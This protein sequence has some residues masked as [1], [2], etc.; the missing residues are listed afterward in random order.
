M[1]DN[2]RPVDGQELPDHGVP[3]AD[4]AA[5]WWEQPSTGHDRSRTDPTMIGSPAQFGGFPGAHTPPP[6]PFA[7]SQPFAAPQPPT[8]PYAAPQPPAYGSPP[9]HSAGP[10]GRFPNRPPTR[11]KTP[12]IIAGAV[13]LVLIVAVTVGLFAIAATVEDVADVGDD[14]SQGD[15]AMDNVTNSCDLVDTTILDNWAPTAQPSTHTERKPSEGIGGGSLNC[16]AKNDG[17]G[18]I[19]ATLTMDADFAYKYSGNTSY[20]TW[21]NSDTGTSGTGRSSGAI[22]GLGEQAYYAARESDS[23]S[24]NK[25]EYTV[26]VKD[27]NVSVQI[28]ITVYAKTSIN[29]SGVAAAC[30]AQARR[31]LDR[32]RK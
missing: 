12:W 4:P 11:S 31:V 25:L 22:P 28:E 16:R 14:K 3:Q 1:T 30:E 17:T 2:K 10:Y 24:F 15:Y 32:L 7:A 9:G 29:R 6:Q 18:I 26:G 5:R 19:E 27:S 23:T 21:K 20:D 13:V 8:P